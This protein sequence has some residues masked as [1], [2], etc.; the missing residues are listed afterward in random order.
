MQER[1]D[2]ETRPWRLGATMFGLFGAVALVVAVVGLYGVV[3]FA[4]TQRS[5][6]IAVRLALGARRRDIL[7]TVAGDGLGAVA[8]GLAIGAVGAFSVRRWVGPL[9]FQTS[10]DDPRLI[11]G[12]AALLFGVAFVAIL[13]PTARAIRLDAAAVLRA[14]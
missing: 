1:V 7:R 14:N 13:L 8:L 5:F 11:L 9:L 2:A 4:V 10:A 3:A 12:I 6:E